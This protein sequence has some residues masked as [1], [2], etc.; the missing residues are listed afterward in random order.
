M[1]TPTH[2]GHT[3]YHALINDLAAVGRCGLGWVEGPDAASFLQG[4][5]TCDIAGIG[6]GEGRIGLLLD[7]KGH[8]VTQLQIVRDAQTSFTLI[9]TAAAIDQLIADLER[10]HFSEDLELIGPEDSACITCRSTDLPALDG[11]IAPGWIPGTIDLVTDDPTSALTHIGRAP[12]SAD[13]VDLLRI[14]CGVPLVG[15]DTGPKTLVQEAGLE[16]RVVDFTKGCYLGQ[17]TVA[18]AQHRGQVHR[19]LR[20]V[21]ATDPLSRGD[22]VHFNGATIGVV[23]SVAQHPELGPVGIGILRREPPD[24]TQVTIGDQAR[25]ATLTTFWS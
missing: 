17:E 13:A 6:I 18:R 7:A 19:V 22:E 21:T 16:G 15:V 24:G 1:T 25:T 4:L 10:F 12:S 14:L 9:T 8:I 23:S 20:G 2:P 5:V 3:T 11:L